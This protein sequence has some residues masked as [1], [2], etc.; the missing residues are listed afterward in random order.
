MDAALKLL[1][2]L[3]TGAALSLRTVLAICDLN[4]QTSDFRR[5]VLQLSREVV[6]PYGILGAVSN[7]QHAASIKVMTEERLL[8]S[9]I[10]ND[11]QVPGLS[12]PVAPMPDVG[13]LPDVPELNNCCLQSENKGIQMPQA[14][15]NR[16]RLLPERTCNP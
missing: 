12:F 16:W 10:N 4:V 14:I 15:I 13:K 2:Y 8:K 6:P 7:D 5:A 1:Q 3:I 11:L 9:A